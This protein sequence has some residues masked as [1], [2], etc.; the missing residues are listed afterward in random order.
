MPSTTT[1]VVL[2]T[3]AG[4]GIGLVVL[5]RLLK[6]YNARVVV[7]TLSPTPELTAVEEEYGK[8]R[9][10]TVYGD[11]RNDHVLAD[12]IER[13]LSNFTYMSH[14]VSC[15]GTMLPVETIRDVSME[16]FRRIFD[17]NF[18]SVVS[19]VQKSLPHL[20]KAPV[21]PTVVIVTSGVDVDVYYRG[22]SGYCSSKAALTRFIQLLAHEEQEM[23]VFG[24]LPLVTKSPM[25]DMIFE[26]AY[27]HVMLPDERERFDKWAKEGKIEHP[28][29]IADAMVK[30]AMGE[31]NPESPEVER[32]VCGAL[33]IGSMYQK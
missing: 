1:P 22:W 29:Y 17:I 23:N 11:A 19:I 4:S 25:V 16:S 27:D 28:D 12:C 5:C 14:L 8:S 18:F 7:L 21:K 6:V 30:A 13:T 26:G 15:I 20:A 31:L 9:L 2:L 33:F 32:N 3:G 24:V 10:V